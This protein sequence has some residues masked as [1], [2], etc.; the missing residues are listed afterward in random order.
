ME[1][2]NHT[3]NE[4][5][6]SSTQYVVPRYQRLY[7]WN[8]D[9]QWAPLWEDVTGIAHDL[10]EQSLNRNST[11]G[12]T[13]AVE[14][15]FFGTIVL[16]QSGYTPDLALRYRVIDGQQRLTT[17]QLM[18]SALAD[19]LLYRGLSG[20]VEPVLKL[21]S[22]SSQ[23]EVFEPKKAKIVHGSDHYAGYIDVM[24]PEKD[25]NV[26]PGS[27]GDSYRFY[28]ESVQN[29]LGDQ[30]ETL[31]TRT[32]ALTTSIL[33]KLRVVAIYLDAHEEE[34]KIFETL[35]ARGEPLT[36]WDKIKN[37]MLYKA[38]EHTETN[39]DEY[40][41]DYL[42]YFDQGWWR[43]KIGRGAAVRPR[44]DVFADYWL[45][46][47]TATAVG[48]SR[49]F[50]EFQKYVNRHTHD[51]NQIGK[52]LIG[53]AEHFRNTEQIDKLDNTAESRFH[54]RRLLIET[55]AWWPMI[56]VLNRFCNSHVVD[57][58]V[59]D[60]CF[61]LLE[62]YL[63]RRVVVGHNARS[64]DQVGFDLM[65]TIQDGDE[66]PNALSNAIRLRLLGYSQAS[67]RWPTDVDVHHAVTTRRLP[68]YSLRLVL[69]AIEVS[70]ITESAGYQGIGNAEVEHIMPQSWETSNWPKPIDLDENEVV[71]RRNAL[72]HSLGNLTLINSGLNKRLSN[73]S[74]QDKQ[75]L[76]SQ[77][78]N[79]F[80]NRLL[81]K[82][83]PEIWNE[84]QIEQRGKWMAKS[85]CE[86]W[87]RPESIRNP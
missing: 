36:E 86:I 54:Y 78:D 66:N 73:R 31:E 52:E 59:R 46:S 50:R 64:Y 81:L 43:E 87:P 40:F 15:H 42:D 77:S 6:S 18:M 45:E 63:V 71:A 23:T 25:K 3:V 29:W 35:N 2:R 82:K 80:V 37:F 26:I 84:D 57:D 14:S 5:F 28:R 19:V 53:D 51:L 68:W 72:I 85:I 47:K 70:L 44:S 32:I 4:L 49:V 79:L 65:K 11:E 74:W 76:I 33:I 17:L 58:D 30:D 83:T 1:P 41:D 39:Q 67:N 69:E 21:I 10:Y 62:S 8:K 38:D 75:K 34:H 24:N 48:S 61:N 20:H 60:E 7:V 27:M 56:F 12:N 9:D 13:D 16:K 55:G 22:N